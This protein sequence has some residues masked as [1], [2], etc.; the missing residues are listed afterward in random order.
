MVP[1]DLAWIQS[2]IDKKAISGPVLELGAGYGGE[3]A[4]SLIKK[5][6]LTY[7]ATDIHKPVG[8][9][10]DFIADFE[11]LA[12]MSVFNSVCPFGSVLIMNV[13]EHTFEPVRV[14]DNALTLL[15]PHGAL[16]V[17]TP[18]IWPL[19]DWPFDAVR[20]LPN[21]YEEYAK[22]RGLDLLADCFEYVGYGQVGNY[23]NPDKSY[24]FPPPH[25]SG[26]S[27]LRSRIVHKVANT[28]GRHM[29]FPSH[30]AIGAVL[31]LGAR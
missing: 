11:D 8:G 26:F 19:H 17:L 25:N 12:S 13:L 5:T 21:F 18:A 10:V 27:R 31:R 6:G 29:F 16:V 28:Y 3:T 24:T 1:Q 7:Y 22:R 20:L 2:L 9:G 15:R 23:L 4:K 14:L 30:V